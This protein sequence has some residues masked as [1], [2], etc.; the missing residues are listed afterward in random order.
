MERHGAQGGRTLAPAGLRP[1]A[2]IRSTAGARNLLPATIR[3]QASPLIGWQMPI[4]P[5]RS[6]RL[7]DVE[8]AFRTLPERYLG[9]DPGFD[10]TY[11]IRLCDLGHTWEVRCTAHGARVRKGA[12]RRAP[13]VTISTDAET[14]LALRAGRDVRHRRLRAPAAER[15][16]QPRLRRRLRGDV[17]APRRPSA[18]P[19]DPRRARRP[20][21]HLL[22][23][24]GP[25]PRRPAAARPGRN[26]RLAVRH[27]RRAGPAL[28]RACARPARVRLLLQARAGALQRPLVRGDDARLHGRPGHLARPRR[29]QLD[30]RPDRH[31]DGADGARARPLAGPAV[32]GGGVGQAR[33]SPAGAAAAAR[34]RASAPRLH[35]Q[36]GR[37]PSS[38]A[39]STT[40][41]SSTP[42]SAS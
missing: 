34:V 13:D 4:T 40:A 17:P 29:R 35:P 39:C 30:G 36:Y 19:A 3:A 25:R 18:A 28:P 9:A 42:R 31:R 32:P 15:H 12:T 16:R 22:A 2:R 23:D 21:P 37:R 26:P 41:T 10:A 27:R 5:D 7:A 1:S 6:R 38:G 33:L 24:H 8:T 14:W 11:S 20:P